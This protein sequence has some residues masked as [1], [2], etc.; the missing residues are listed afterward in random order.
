MNFSHLSS[1][2]FNSGLS[3]MIISNKII[4]LSPESHYQSKNNSKLSYE[5][6]LMTSNGIFIE[7]EEN[8]NFLLPNLPSIS[9]IQRDKHKNF[10][11]SK[12]SGNFFFEQRNEN[13]ENTHKKIQDIL[14]KV[15]KSSLFDVD[16]L[17]L[18]KEKSFL[19]YINAENDQYIHQNL[20]RFFV[21]RSTKNKFNGIFYTNDV[22]FIIKYLK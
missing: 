13:E 10:E 20:N 16:K 15:D 19:P 6:P 14:F 5:S 22:N 4:K 21:F 11:S 7:E 8:Y 9:E 2:H 12:N 18:K 17:G 3:Q 1:P